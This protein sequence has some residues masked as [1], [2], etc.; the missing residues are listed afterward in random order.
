[1]EQRFRYVG[2]GR[3]VGPDNR[4]GALGRSAIHQTW[5]VISRHE[6]VTGLAILF[7]LLPLR[8][9]ASLQMSTECLFL[10]HLIIPPPQNDSLQIPCP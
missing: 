5:C 3:Y 9:D 10:L 1:M 8:L 4:E 2:A 7:Y 6:G